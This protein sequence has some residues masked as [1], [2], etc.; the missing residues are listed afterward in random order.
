MFFRRAWDGLQINTA[1]QPSNAVS[2]EQRQEQ[3][4]QLLFI[5]AFV[6]CVA[7]SRSTKAASLLN[8]VGGPLC[9]CVCVCLSE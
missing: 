8:E 5:D 7:A 9:V 4:L 2:Q 6:A 3:R 1:V